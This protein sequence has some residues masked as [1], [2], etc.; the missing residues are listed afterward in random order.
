MGGPSSSPMLVCPWRPGILGRAARF[1]DVR[2]TALRRK[3]NRPGL[4]SRLKAGLERGGT[5]NRALHSEDEDA[6]DPA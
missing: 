2:S 3:G 4:H 5:T 1:P 6:Y